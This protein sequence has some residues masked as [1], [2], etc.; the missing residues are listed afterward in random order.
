MTLFRIVRVCRLKWFKESK[1]QW[2]I[3]PVT[4]RHAWAG[5][6]QPTFCQHAKNVQYKLRLAEEEKLQ[7]NTVEHNLPLSVTQPLSPPP[8]LCCSFKLQDPPQSQGPPPPHTVC[9]LAFWPPTMEMQQATTTSWLLNSWPHTIIMGLMLVMAAVSSSCP[10]T[11]Q[12]SAGAG[13]R[14]PAVCMVGPGGPAANQWY[15]STAGCSGK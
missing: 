9:S 2:K 7:D 13:W 12:A 3:D 11:C 6:R 5:K 10:W 4:L 1:W 14:L 15:S 8:R